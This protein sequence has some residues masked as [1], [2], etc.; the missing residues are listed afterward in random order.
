MIKEYIMDLTEEEIYNLLK[1]RYE[2]QLAPKCTYFR[3]SEYTVREPVTINENIKEQN[4]EEY[5]F[6]EHSTIT[7]KTFGYPDDPN[8]EYHFGFQNAMREGEKWSMIVRKNETVTYG[9]LVQFRGD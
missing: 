9:Y 3:G 8:E 2:I 5:D 1:K 7:Y 4:D 6:W